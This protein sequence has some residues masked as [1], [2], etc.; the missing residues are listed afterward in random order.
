MLKGCQRQIVVMRGKY[1]DIFEEVHFVLRAGACARGLPEML[2]EAN[3][4]IET[5]S[6][7]RPKHCRGSGGVSRLVFFAL[8]LLSGAAIALFSVAVT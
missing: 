2:S 3:R 6:P 1:G 8:G 5:V 7:G 4:I